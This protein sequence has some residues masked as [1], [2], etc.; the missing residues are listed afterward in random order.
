MRTVEYQDNDY[1]YMIQ[2][3]GSLYFGAKYS[4]QEIM[5]EEMVNFKFKSIIEHYLSKD[6]D[7]STTIESHLY[8]MTPEQF[9]YRTYEQL[10]ARVKVSVMEEKKS[11]FGKTKTGYSTKVIHL[12]E[13]AGWNLAQKKAKGLFIQE[14]IISK[15][16]LMMFSV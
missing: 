9:S 12:N 7:L 5:E 3:T 4:Y 11:L 2:D 14:I 10:K 16:A 15:L 8:Y 13:L 6:T 1:K